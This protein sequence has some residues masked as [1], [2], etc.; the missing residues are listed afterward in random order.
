MSEEQTMAEHTRGRLKATRFEKCFFIDTEDTEESN[1]LRIAD[2]EGDDQLSPETCRANARRLVAAW[3]F[4][5]GISTED[6]ETKQAAI[7][8]PVPRVRPPFYVEPDSDYDSPVG[9]S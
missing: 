1:G 5:E 6:L 8:D 7:F 9:H 3:N 4:C 2:V